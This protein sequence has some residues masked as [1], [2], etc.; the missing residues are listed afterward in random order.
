MLRQFLRLVRELEPNRHFLK[1]WLSQALSLTAFNMVNFTLLIRVFELTG[2]ATMVSLFVLSF[3]LPSLLFGAVAGVFADRWHRRSVLIV[4]NVLRAGLV[5]LYLTD[6]SSVPVLLAVTFA[7]STVTQFFTPAEGAA[8]PELV[9]PKRLVAAN[10]VFI[11]TMFA[12]FVVGYGLAGP[13]AQIG[14]DSLPIAVAA[15]SFSIAALACAMLPPLHQRMRKVALRDA[16]RSV[17]RD[18]KAGLAVIRKTPLVR[19]GLLQMTAVWTVIGVVMVLLPAYVGE[20]LGANLREV[21]RI[22]ILP[23][24]VGMLAGGV[25]L[26]RARRQ[27]PVRAVVTGAL[28][29]AGAMVALLG[30]VEPAAAALARATDGNAAALREGITSAS[31]TVLGLSISMVM[32]ASQTLIHEQTERAMR[33]RVFGFLGMSVNA[34]NT[35]PVLLAGALVDFYAVTSVVTALGVLLLF[36]AVVSL[37]AGRAAGRA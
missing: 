36:W 18:L 25:A 26:H 4:T 13:V 27:F 12:S 17:L 33:G 20:V 29:T 23:V 9:E 37:P 15:G 28:L 14:G 2:S 6:L 11:V 30:Q 22:V 8:I 24:G 32:I 16:Y 1:L 5:L 31:A 21:S 10:A 35:V 3:G 34:A 19:Y 7:V